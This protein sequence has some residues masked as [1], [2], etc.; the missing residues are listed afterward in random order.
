[1]SESELIQLF[2][3]HNDIMRILKIVEELKLSDCWLCAGVLRQTVWNSLSGQKTALDD[4]IDI[5]IVFYDKSLSYEETQMIE[6]TLRTSYPNYNWELKNQ[7]YMHFHNPDTAPYCHT[8]D[9][10]TKFPETCTALALRLDN[11]VIELF[12]PHGIE[13]LINFRV[14]ATPHFKATDARR[15]AYNQRV[16]AKNWLS[17]WPNLLIELES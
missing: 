8:R 17:K 10:I 9:A 11:Q 16:L 13:D 15:K 2:L 4:V 5:D 14:A 7:V 1:M 3:E 12:V 6:T